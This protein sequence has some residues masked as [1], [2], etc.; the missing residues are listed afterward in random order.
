LLLLRRDWLCNVVLFRVYGAEQLLQVR[1]ALHYCNIVRHSAL[2]LLRCD[3]AA[4]ARKVLFDIAL[5]RIVLIPGTANTGC[6]PFTTYIGGAGRVSCV[7]RQPCHA[8]HGAMPCIVPWCHGAMV[9]ASTY[10]VPFIL[11][12]MYSRFMCSAIFSK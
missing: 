6:A 2:V 3:M 10:R 1:M 4:H 9:P 12:P 11:V 5:H 7:R 8:M